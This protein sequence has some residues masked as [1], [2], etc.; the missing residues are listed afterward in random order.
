MQRHYRGSHTALGRPMFNAVFLSNNMQCVQ[1]CSDFQENAMSKCT[2][3][4]VNDSR[5]IIHPKSKGN[6]LTSTNLPCAF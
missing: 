5:F 2:I 1:N 6:R 4:Q 3:M